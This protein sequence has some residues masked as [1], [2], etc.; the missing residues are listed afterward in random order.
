[1]GRAM[2][3]G[4][5]IERELEDTDIH[6]PKNAKRIRRN[7]NRIKKLGQVDRRTVYNDVDVL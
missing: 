5:L 7:I 6:H 3:R 1:M 2:E 4:F